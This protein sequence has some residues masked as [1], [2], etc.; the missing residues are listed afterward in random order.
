M[1]K[2]I[3]LSQLKAAGACANA[4]QCFAAA[5][6]ES[7]QVTPSL[8]CKHA[9]QFSWGWAASYLLSRPARAEYKIVEARARAKCNRTSV[10]AQAKYD[11]ACANARQRFAS[12]SG[13]YDRAVAPARAEYAR[14]VTQA[15]VEYKQAIA[16]AWATLYIKEGV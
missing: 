14:A 5:F 8:A 11:R 9:D 2:I 1:C 3:T 16:R 6:G 12:A 7:V 10:S 13:E 4:L 15:L